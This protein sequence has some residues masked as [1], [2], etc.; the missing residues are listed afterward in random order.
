MLAARAT[1]AQ[2]ARRVESGRSQPVFRTRGVAQTSRGADPVLW[3]GAPYLRSG[4]GRVG[5]IDSQRKLIRIEEGKGRKDRYVTLSERLLK[6]RRW[7]YRA[8]KPKEYLFP[9]W[10]ETSHETGGHLAGLPQ[11]RPTGRHHQTG[12]APY[13]APLYRLPDYAARGIGATASR[14]ICWIGRRPA[15]HSTAVGPQPYRNHRPLHPRLGASHRRHRQP[16]RRAGK[17]GEEE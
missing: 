12:H 5:D 7:Y 11:C 1:G 2:A 3:R 9:S 4:Q 14:L 6:I 10:R 16:T 15:H 13:V 8:T 17:A